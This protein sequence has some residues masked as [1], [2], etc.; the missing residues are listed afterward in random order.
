VYA[1]VEQRGFASAAFAAMFYF[2]NI[3]F[4][5]TANNYFESGLENNPFLHTWSLA[6]EEQFYIVW[7]ALL[8]LAARNVTRD[9]IR[10]RLV[11]LLSIT[12]AI[13]LGMCMYVTSKDQPWAFFSMPTRM[14]EFGLGA[15]AVLL[16]P[17]GN[18]LPVYSSVIMGCLGAL[19][20]VWATTQFDRNSTFPGYAALVPVFGTCLLLG[21]GR[22]TTPGLVSRLLSISPMCWLGDISYSWYL[23]H[24]PALLAARQ[25]IGPTPSAALL[26]IL[27]SLLVAEVS[28]R[29]VE[30]P[31]RRSPALINRVWVSLATGAQS[32]ADQLRCSRITSQSPRWLLRSRKL[33]QKL[34]TI[35]R[36]R[37]GATR[38]SARWT[39][40]IACLA[41]FD[42]HG[43]LCCSAIPTRI[44]GFQ[45]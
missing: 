24:W 36:Q 1:P 6:V 8:F 18:R 43:R 4:A 12:G 38:P 37:A 39:C 28:Y 41:T 42:R 5:L 29:F 2:S 32:W 22:A 34:A 25:F 35:D 45:P 27:G 44:T 14:W 26:A 33:I 30:N 40:Q 9:R 11:L 23:W 20:I 15:L 10:S 16:L 17:T 3:W 13:S 31:V 7:P 19:L 21:A